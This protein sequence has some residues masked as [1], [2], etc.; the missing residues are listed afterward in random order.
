MTLNFEAQQREILL[1]VLYELK[2]DEK[3][4][5]KHLDH[6]KAR[7]QGQREAFSRL[8]TRV[9]QASNGIDSKISVL[10]SKESDILQQEFQSLC[11]MLS[12]CQRQTIDENTILER[13]NQQG[14]D[15]IAFL[16]YPLAFEEQKVFELGNKLEHFK[17]NMVLSDSYIQKLEEKKQ[18]LMNSIEEINEKDNIIIRTQ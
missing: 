5:R 7:I 9:C 2:C 11:D 6:Q 3:A 17:R 13:S 4:M 12:K 14:N 18:N 16:N 10:Y 1:N 8:Q 15:Q